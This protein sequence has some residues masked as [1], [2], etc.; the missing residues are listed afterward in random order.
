MS[1]FF[2]HATALP[3]MRTAVLA[4]VIRILHL[5]VQPRKRFQ[6]KRIS[7]SSTTTAHMRMVVRLRRSISVGQNTLVNR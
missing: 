1:V 6:G 5:K 4:L 2:A 7:R 3:T